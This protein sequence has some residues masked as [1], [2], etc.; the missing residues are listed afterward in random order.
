[1]TRPG[2][3]VLCTKPWTSFEV[4]DHKGVVTPCC[5]SK[6]HCGNVNDS[7]FEEIWNG[8]AYRRMRQHMAEGELDLICSEWCPYRHGEH[9]DVTYP[10]PQSEE[11]RVNWELQREEIREGRTVLKSKPTILNVCPSVKCNLDCVMCFQDRNDT[12]ELPERFEETVEAHFPTLQEV[13][14]IGGEPLIAKECLDIIGRADPDKYPDLH[15]G[16]ITNGTAVSPKAQD[17][18]RSRRLSWVLV[19]IDAATPETFKKIRRGKLDKVLD[20]VR[21][22]KELREL[23]D[24][25]WSLRIGFTVMRSNMHEA[26][27]FA[28]L[29][30]GLGVECQLTPVF[31][32]NPE[33]FHDDPEAVERCK[34]I[35]LELGDRLE[36]LGADRLR[37]APVWSR[38]SAATGPEPPP[39]DTCAVS[40]EEWSARLTG[41]PGEAGR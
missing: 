34:R 37:I 2:L 7:T 14:V 3:P 32:D 19:S 8:P 5:W 18:L 38:L 22:L 31:G 23:Q 15:V 24:G 28:N 20:G 30:H 40:F 21:K 41:R 29:A 35:M 25:K 10:P 39:L 16:L 13:W 4:N 33:N 1:M 26:I 17:L 36:E 9:M 27:D 6:L 11:F 12:A